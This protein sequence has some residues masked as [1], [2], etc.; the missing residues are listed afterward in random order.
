MS[1]HD[2]SNTPPWASMHLLSREMNCL[3]L[4]AADLQR[5]TTETP[6]WVVS[7]LQC[8]Q[9]GLDEF[10]PSCSPTRRNPTGFRSG[11]RGGHCMKSD[12]LD[13]SLP[14]N[15]S[16]SQSIAILEVWAGA[17]SCIKT[18]RLLTSSESSGKIPVNISVYRSQ[19]WIPHCWS[20]W[21]IQF[22]LDS[23][24]CVPASYD[25]SYPYA[26]LELTQIFSISWSCHQLS[27]DWL[28]YQFF[29]WSFF[30][31]PVMIL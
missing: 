3:S 29:S 7:P 18:V 24:E 20:Q 16:S 21:G 31:I 2:Y 12:L 6:G 13:I 23:L 10:L 30:L 15:L 9:A 25:P 4:A 19:I 22:V 27:S 11:D 1:T 14:G 28:F 26:D 5:S 17:P 8:C